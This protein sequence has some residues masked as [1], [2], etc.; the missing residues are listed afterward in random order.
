MAY[1][2]YNN[3]GSVLTTIA[4]GDIDSVSTSLDLVGKNVNNYGQYFNNNFTKLLTNFASGEPPGSERT[5][6]LWYDTSKPANKILRIYNG[7]EW[8]PVYG[9]TISSTQPIS[10]STGEL[11]F[12]PTSQQLFVYTTST[13]SG[14]WNLIG[15]AVS[16][17]LGKF[18]IEPPR[19]KI[20]DNNFNQEQRISVVYSYGN[21]AAL[22]TTSSFTMS[23]SSSTVYFNNNTT[24]NIVKGVTVIDNLDVRGDLF[25]RG[26]HKVDKNLTAYYEVNAWADPI[27]SGSLSINDRYDS[28][29]RS[30]ATLTNVILPGLF[31]NTSTFYGVNS[32]AR[33]VTVY[34]TATY[35]STTIRHFRLEEFIP[36]ALNWRPYNLYTATYISNSLTNIIS[37]S[38]WIY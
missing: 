3:D 38:S 6:Q 32:E 29:N 15:P 20:Y 28:L 30:N 31:P 36:G 23:A 11:W 1:I 9:T 5:G 4:E 17:Q 18:G 33:V 14:P 19:V 34:S 26:R 24:T 37:T 25:V 13:P 12:N 16:S 27:T 21:P 10:T 2:I 22:I 7:T 35:R 8:K